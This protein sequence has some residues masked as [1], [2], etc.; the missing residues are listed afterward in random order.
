M[1]AEWSTGRIDRALARNRE[2]LAGSEP[3]STTPLIDLHYLLR[4][5]L[6]QGRGW[7]QWP[8]HTHRNTCCARPHPYAHTHTCAVIFQ[9]VSGPK[10]N[11]SK[12]HKHSSKLWIKCMDLSLENGQRIYIVYVLQKVTG[13]FIFFYYYL[14][15]VAQNGDLMKL[16]SSENGWHGNCG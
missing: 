8:K 5:K 13:R 11:W 3:A 16:A 12:K 1:L 14:S 15:N 4:V 10:V 6:E 7:A 2:T 9:T